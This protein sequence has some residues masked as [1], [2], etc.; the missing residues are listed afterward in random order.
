MGRPR[1]P[2]QPARLPWTALRYIRLMMGLFGLILKL[3]WKKISS[4][5]RAAS[6]LMPWT[7]YKLTENTVSSSPL[8]LWEHDKSNKGNINLGALFNFSFL[9]FF[10]F[11]KMLHSQTGLVFYGI[12]LVYYLYFFPLDR[13]IYIQ[14]QFPDHCFSNAQMIKTP[15][16]CV[17]PKTPGGR[18]ISHHYSSKYFSSSHWL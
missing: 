6:F 16:N 11:L 1:V 14:K 13:L 2:Q 18:R 9:F 3:G 4:W 12:G 8:K 17:V 7:N 10:S 15:N 5:N